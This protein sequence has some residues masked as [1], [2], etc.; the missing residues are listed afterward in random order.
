MIRSVFDIPR[1]G[2]RSAPAGAVGLTA[3]MLLA[4][5]CYADS[6]SL[7]GSLGGTNGPMTVTGVLVDCSAAESC[8]L[9]VR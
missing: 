6:V 2:T 8:A 7:A 9:I 4:A 5:P 3:W 1:P